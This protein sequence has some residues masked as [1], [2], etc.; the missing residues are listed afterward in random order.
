M[1]TKRYS[2]TI[3]ISYSKTITRATLNALLPV[4]QKELKVI[5]FITVVR[6]RTL[7]SEHKTD[8]V[9]IPTRLDAERAGDGAANEIRWCNEEGGVTID[10]LEDVRAV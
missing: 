3:Y 4:K 10:A 9:I 6:N 2:V 1:I 5:Y 8:V 7:I